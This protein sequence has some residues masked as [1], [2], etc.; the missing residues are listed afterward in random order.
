MSTYLLVHGTWHGAWNWHRVVPLFEQLGHQAIAIDLPGHGTDNTPAAEINLQTYVDCVIKVI[1]QQ[2]DK[3][4]LLAHSGNG[5]VISEVA[6]QRPD[7]I[8]KLIYLAAYLAQNGQSF[9]DLYGQDQHSLLPHNSSID[10]E[11]GTHMI[12]SEIYQQALYADCTPEINAL[13]AN[14]LTPEPNLPRTQNISISEKNFGRVPRYYIECLNDKAVSLPLQRLMHKAMPC[15]QVLSLQSS[16]SPFFSQ[17]KALV[18]TVLS[19]N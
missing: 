13:A 10:A 1:D 9:F 8:D 12:N 4:I 16:H 18:E 5:T 15:R 11:A 6:E 14:L 3:V 17:P 7:K 19:L 2:Q